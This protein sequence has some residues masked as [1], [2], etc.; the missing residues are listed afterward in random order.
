M[1]KSGVSAA[2]LWL[3]W[4]IGRLLKHHEAWRVETR[5]SHH[6][7][8]VWKHCATGSFCSK[9]PAL[10]LGTSRMREGGE[11]LYMGEFREVEDEQWSG[12]VIKLEFREASTE[13]LHMGRAWIRCTYS[14]PTQGLIQQILL[15]TS[16]AVWL[17]IV[18]NRYFIV[19][20]QNIAVRWYSWCVLSGY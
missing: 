12:W 10:R 18:T 19:E 7:L 20:D 17:F 3:R 5:Q 4:G 1:W 2:R 8:E 6:C 13:K 11:L 16:I 9:T 15:S 14:M